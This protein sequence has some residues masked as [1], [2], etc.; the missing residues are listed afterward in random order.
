[1]NAYLSPDVLHQ[2]SVSLANCFLVYQMVERTNYCYYH[3]INDKG[4]FYRGSKLPLFMKLDC[5][6][7]NKNIH[8]CY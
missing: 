5:I 6:Y 8:S 7:I 2:Y 1:M 3:P 4:T